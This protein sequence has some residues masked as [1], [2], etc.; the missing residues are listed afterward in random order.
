MTI[1][2]DT[3]EGIS[4]SQIEEAAKSLDPES[5]NKA[6]NLKFALLLGLPQ[7]P[8]P[9]MLFDAFLLGLCYGLCITQDKQEVSD[10]ERMIRP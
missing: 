10:L 8:I 7:V 6:I 5:I 4:K 1:T 2:K 3:L 9:T